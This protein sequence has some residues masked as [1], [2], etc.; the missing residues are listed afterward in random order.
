MF[1]FL[2]YGISRKFRFNNEALFRFLNN[3]QVNNYI[4]VFLMS[5]F[6]LVGKWIYILFSFC[7]FESTYTFCKNRITWIV[8]IYI[9]T[10]VGV[11]ALPGIYL[12]I[13][14]FI[15][16]SILMPMYSCEWIYMNWFM[17]TSL[18]SYINSNMFPNMY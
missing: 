5:I 18:H 7:I 15:N 16:T 12:A 10:F 1:Q 4:N 17:Y 11:I 13:H 3:V 14:I 6:L 8:S 2:R 9:D